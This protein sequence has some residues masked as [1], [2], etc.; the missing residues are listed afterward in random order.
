MPPIVLDGAEEN[1]NSSDYAKRCRE[2]LDLYRDLK[3]L[4]YL[5]V[6]L[7]LVGD[8]LNIKYSVQTYFDLPRVVVIGGQSSRHP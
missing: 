3:D 6:F 5:F 8:L 1:I 2:V 7:Q 4:G